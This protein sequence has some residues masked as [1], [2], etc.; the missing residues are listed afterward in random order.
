MI[1]DLTPLEALEIIKTMVNDVQ[2]ASKIPSIDDELEIIEKALNDYMILLYIFRT[3]NHL[4]DNNYSVE[5]MVKKARAFEIFKNKVLK[6][7]WLGVVFKDRTNIYDIEYRETPTK[8][9][10]ELL[11]EILK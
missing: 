5:Y 11:E 7:K 8:E 9:E 6:I 1:K 10:A 2:F 3:I 4:N